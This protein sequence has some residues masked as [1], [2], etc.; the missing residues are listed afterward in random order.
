MG[1]NTLLLLASMSFGSIL[2]CDD[3]TTEAPIKF[4][5]SIYF[6][7]SPSH[8]NVCFSNDA[9]SDGV[10]TPTPSPPIELLNM[11]LGEQMLQM[12][13]IVC[14]GKCPSHIL[15]GFPRASSFSIVVANSI[16]V[17][18]LIQTFHANFF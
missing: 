13:N 18:N 15:E 17:V 3:A 16:P 7:F 14:K 6:S 5:V 8:V 2:V 9:S 12:S 11:P 1:S 4:Q 10:F